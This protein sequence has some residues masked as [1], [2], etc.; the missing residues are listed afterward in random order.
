MKEQVLFPS[1]TA[2]DVSA[3]AVF[4]LPGLLPAEKRLLLDPE[5]HTALLLAGEGSGA[6]LVVRLT[7]SATAVFL[8]LLQA[9]PSACSY[10]ALFRSLYSPPPAPDERDRAWERALAV[11]P[12]RRALKAL[13]PALRRFGFQVISLRG[14]GYVLASAHDPTMMGSVTQRLIAATERGQDVSP[15]D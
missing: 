9:Y 14:Q 4:V 7:P 5:T 3:A 6:A 11:P 13:L 8:R 10:Q 1:T 12:I 15:S 2:R